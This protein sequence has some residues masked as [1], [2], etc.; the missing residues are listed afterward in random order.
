MKRRDFLKL[1]RRGCRSPAARTPRRRPRRAWWWSA[2]A[3]AAPPR[4]S[5]SACGTRRSTWCWSS[6][7]PRSSPARSPTWCSAATRSM[8]DISRGYDGLREHGVQVVR[9]EVDRDRRGE[10]NGAPRA[11]RRPRLRAPDR[12][13]RASTSSS[14]RCRATRRRCRRAACCTPGR[15]GRRPWRCAAARADARRRRLRPLHPDGAVP[16]PAGPVRARLHGR[17]LLQAGEAALQGAGARR[18]PRRHLQGGRCSSAPG[19]TSTRA[20]SSTAA[21]ASAVGVDGSAQHREARARRREGRRAERG[22]A[23]PRR[24]HRAA[25]PA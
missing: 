17:G 23:A 11:R 21:T 7:T 22:A 10:E 5:T 6:A 18:Q 12:L 24:R 2:A 15:P 8:D 9:D 20:S 16:L 14:A 1:A 25:R 19:A 3:S 13:A 4:R